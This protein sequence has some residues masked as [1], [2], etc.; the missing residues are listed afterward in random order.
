M[1]YQFVRAM[2]ESLEGIPTIDS[3]C[4]HYLYNSD[5]SK[6]GVYYPELETYFLNK[7]VSEY[8][9]VNKDHLASIVASALIECTYPVQG[10]EYAWTTKD[11]C[12]STGISRSW[13][14][15]KGYDKIARS[16]ID[17]VRIKSDEVEVFTRRQIQD[18]YSSH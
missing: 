18:Y 9:E 7:L 11:R 4:Y 10:N 8:P 3:A 12:L 2:A 15:L 1:Q 5:S 14:Y 16:I 17:S 13:W 6:R